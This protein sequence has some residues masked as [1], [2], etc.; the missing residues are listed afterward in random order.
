MGRRRN[1][2]KRELNPDPKYNSALVERVVNGVMKCGRKTTAQRIVYGAM[3]ELAEQTG[4]DPIEVLDAAINNMKP[5]VEVKSRRVGG[6]TY[7][8]PVEIRPARQLA[9]ALRW[10]LQYAAG[11]HGAGMPKAVALELIDAYNNQG[12]VIKKRDETHKMAQ[13]NRAFAHYAW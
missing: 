9:L 5:K 13:A 4:K 8:V 6:T 2:T 10:M 1:A 3:A 12:N 11:R 7:Q